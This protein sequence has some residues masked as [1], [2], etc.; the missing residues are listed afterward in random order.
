MKITITLKPDEKYE[1]VYNK[2]RNYAYDSV[3]I[4]ITI[5]VDHNVDF[6]SVLIHKI[7]IITNSRYPLVSTIYVSRK[8]KQKEVIFIR[9][10]MKN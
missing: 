3:N 6:I 7:N 5:T 1:N 9:T 4:K 8:D 2:F 10:P